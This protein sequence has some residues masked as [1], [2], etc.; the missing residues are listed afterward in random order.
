MQFTGGGIGSQIKLKMGQVEIEYVSTTK[1]KLWDHRKV[2]RR[3]DP[4][5]QEIVGM[6]MRIHL[7]GECL[8]RQNLQDKAPEKQLN[9][10]LFSFLAEFSWEGTCGSRVQVPCQDSERIWC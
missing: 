6:S 1:E 9:K 10:N 2:P 5:Q 7:K 4:S 3:Q 8:G